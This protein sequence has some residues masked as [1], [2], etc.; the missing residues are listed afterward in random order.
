V[1][2]SDKRHDYG[3][4]SFVAAAGQ[5]LRPVDDLPGL[6]R[7]GAGS[8]VPG[9]AD[10]AVVQ[11]RVPGHPGQLAV[12]HTDERA[13]PPIERL[14]RDH[15]PAFEQAA[16]WRSQHWDRVSPVWVRRI[17]PSALRMALGPGQHEEVAQVIRRMG[18]ASL[19]VVELEAGDRSL[20]W[21]ALG[22]GPDRVEFGAG[23]L[24]AAVVIARR[25]ALILQATVLMQERSREA[26][27]R[28]RAE[29]S[30]RKWS[31]AFMHAGWGAAIIDE[32]SRSIEAVN[33]AFAQ[34]HGFEDTAAVTGRLFD[35][36]FLGPGGESAAGLLPTQGTVTYETRH[37]R[38]DD[39]AAFPVMVG[40]TAVPGEGGAPGHYA[41]YVQDLSELKRAEERLREVERLEA[42]GRL[43]GGVAHEVNNMMTI[44]IGYAD[45]VLNLPELSDEAK[46]E[47]RQIRQAADHAAGVS[48]QLLAY[49]RQ[50]VLRPEVVDLNDIVRHAARFLAPLLPKDI[51][52]DIRLGQGPDTG[53]HVDRGQLERIIVNLALNA[54]DAMPGGGR[55]ELATD[56]RDVEG[57][58]G[59][60]WLGFAV[61]PGRYAFITAKDTGAGMDSETQ[62]H[63]FEPFF[64]TKPV[65]QGTGLG[66]STTYG[67]VKQSG[68]YI[69]VESA[70]GAGTT[71]TLCFPAVPLEV[72]PRDRRARG[73]SNGAGT[74]LVVDD[75]P[76][77]RNVCTRL[78][79]ERGYDAIEAACGAD[80]LVELEQ[81]SD[82]IR[83]VLTDIVMADMSGPELRARVAARW[84]QVPVMFMSGHP[85]P[86]LVERGLLAEGEHLLQK[87]F[88]AADLAAAVGQVRRRERRLSA[89]GRTS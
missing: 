40:L 33:P 51:Q 77:V 42:V 25:L 20:G 85:G 72:Q 15:L 6:V 89:E 50:Q 10:V 56:A 66:L 46:E 83:A 82:A 43:A 38:A 45:L 44:V 39:H 21:V 16:R 23:E 53:V 30:L 22:R 1:A 70:P 29:A 36:I 7:A 32:R 4:L 52:L 71:F 49:S 68:G 69:W 80:A 8:L 18:V 57:D 76:A 9:L 63:L 75:E 59:V 14:V 3:L 34:L 61:P 26:A 35:E 48:K 62:A 28:S 17:T 11:C 64:T 65:G 5:E 81:G 60:Q 31:Q 24:A 84:P 54:R 87:P 86:E 12:A 13:A 78:L 37:R 67:I 88:T 73:Q 47:L 27:A 19:I 55:F 74:I 41:A 58:F 79:R 2:H